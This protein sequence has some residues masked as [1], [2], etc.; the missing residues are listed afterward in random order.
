MSKDVA[1][2][3]MLRF[4]TY[5]RLTVTRCENHINPSPDIQAKGIKATGWGVV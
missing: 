4:T 2:F 5:D 1:I 3:K